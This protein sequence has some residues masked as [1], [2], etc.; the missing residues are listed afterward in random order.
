MNARF[1]TDFS[2]TECHFFRHERQYC[3]FDGDW[4]RLCSPSLSPPDSRP[5]PIQRYSWPLHRSHNASR[6][7]FHSHFPAMGYGDRYTLRFPA[8]LCVWRGQEQLFQGKHIGVDLS[9]HCGRFL[10]GR[11]LGRYRD[12]GGGP[13]R[14]TC[15]RTP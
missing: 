12:D 5:R 10:S 14:Y 4:L 2:V 15:F 6:S 1:G 3:T 7:H 8:Q 13:L 11:I 9:S